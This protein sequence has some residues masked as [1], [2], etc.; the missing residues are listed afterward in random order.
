[1]KLYLKNPYNNEDLKKVIKLLTFSKLGKF[2]S[3]PGREEVPENIRENLI[4]E[5]YSKQ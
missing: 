1:M 2:I 3:Y 4:V 5:F